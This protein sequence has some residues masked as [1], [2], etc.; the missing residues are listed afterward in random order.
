VGLTAVAAALALHGPALRAPLIY[1]DDFQILVASWTWPAARANLWLPMNEHAMPLGRL[2]TWGLA[3][4]GGGLGAMPWLTA[5]QGPLA[6][7][8][9]MALLYAFVRRELGHPFYGLAAMSLFGVT[10]VYQ[11]AVDWFAASFSVLALDTLLLALLAAQRWRQTGRP[12]YLGL[13]ALAAGLA[14]AWFASGI[15]AGPLCCVY[16]LGDAS[17]RPATLRR[18]VANLVPLLGSAAFLAVSLPRSADYI[19]HLEHYQM[20]GKTNAVEA[21]DPLVGLVNTGRSVVDN[22]ALGVFGIS[23]VECPPLLVPVALALLAAACVWW[24]RPARPRRLLWLGLAFILFNYLLVYSARAAWD[25]SGHMTQWP[26]GRYH[27]LPQLGLTLLV[28]GGLPA[29]QPRLFQLDPSGRLT[30][31]QAGALGWL[32]AVLVVVQAPRAMLAVNEYEPEQARVFRLIDDT[33]A[34][35]RAHHIDAA[36]ARAALEPLNYGYFGRVNGWEF[37]RGSDDPRPVP[38]EEARRLLQP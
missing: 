37:L 19:L 31:A 22:L 17:W 16:L 32:I 12:V 35:C 11:Q 26:W 13:C 34:R 8:A 25:Y 36:T 14:P 10:S 3:R 9:G 28:V 21:F 33:D 23:A 29:R 7:A 24:W 1:F 20:R 4:L 18:S 5:L 30:P 2:S 27:L 6:L 38:V 15:L